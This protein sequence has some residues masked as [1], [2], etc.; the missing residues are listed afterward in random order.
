MNSAGDTWTLSLASRK[1]IPTPIAALVRWEKIVCLSQDSQGRL[2]TS[3][4]GFP[5]SHVAHHAWTR[6]T[7]K[8]RGYPRSHACTLPYPED[9]VLLALY[10]M[11]R[12]R[13]VK[14]GHQGWHP[15]KP[16]QLTRRLKDLFGCAI[17][18]GSTGDNVHSLGVP[19]SSRRE[20]HTPYHIARQQAITAACLNWRR[21]VWSEWSYPPPW[22]L[23][24]A[25]GHV[26]SYLSKLKRNS[27]QRHYLSKRT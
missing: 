12:R 22:P 8:R 1:P 18:S 26:Q 25:S 4:G 15:G 7:P 21:C 19:Q 17:S 14:P 20:T 24:A 2:V 13:K 9:A 11:G 5:S 16:I 10:P 6:Q 3:D 23:V 27:T